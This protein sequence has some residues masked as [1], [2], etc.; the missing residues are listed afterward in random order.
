MTRSSG[1]Y[2]RQSV[3]VS[4]I[5][6]NAYCEDL[7]FSEFTHKQNAIALGTAINGI[8]YPFESNQS[9]HL[10]TSGFQDPL[11]SH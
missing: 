11:T 7:K 5:L 3:S 10:M 4:L 2:I 1:L 9:L 8:L 6:T